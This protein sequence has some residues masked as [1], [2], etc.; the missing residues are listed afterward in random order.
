MAALGRS[1]EM[2]FK[3]LRELLEADDSVLSKSIAHLEKAGYVRVTKGYAGSR[4]KTWVQASANG[5]RAF[6]AH[7]AAL[8]AITES[9]PSSAPDDEATELS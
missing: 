8:R 9:I 7:L 3:A 5:Y 4:P 2:D 1:T 6:Q